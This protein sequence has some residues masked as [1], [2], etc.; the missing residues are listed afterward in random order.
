M[1]QQEIIIQTSSNLV[2][3]GADLISKL[4]YDL[5][6]CLFV[7][8]KKIWNK[9]CNN[10]GKKFF[11]Q[12]DEVLILKDPECNEK[13]AKK[14]IDRVKNYQLIIGFGSG[15]INDLCKYSA[16]QQGIKYVIFPSACSMNG[17]CSQSSSITINGHKKSIQSKSPIAI[18][19]DL[20]IL[21]TAP[22]KMIKAGI[23]DAFCLYSCW[24][25]WLLSH[26]VFNSEF[27]QQCFSM[28]I[29]IINK[30]QKNYHK[31][32]L[33][34]EE[35][36]K[37]LI[38]FLLI[39]SQAMNLANGSYPASQSEHL[40]AHCLTMKYPKQL[41]KILHG[42]L[43]AITVKESLKFQQEILQNLQKKQFKIENIKS[44]WQKKISN[45]FGKITAKEC[46][47]QYRQ[48]ILSPQKIL[49]L[50]AKLNKNQQKIFLQLQEIYK[51]N[52]QISKILKHF[53]IE[54]KWQKISISKSQ[55]FQCVS[56]AK[57]IR[58]RIT[59]LDFF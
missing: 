39:S 2:K 23:S 38:E 58:N 13:F 16:S 12:I 44:N 8:D 57:F 29:E 46:I 24:F 32:N 55:Y 33:N 36:Q 43:I 26:L 31:F 53:K 18:F 7:S 22:K 45:F 56:H 49:Q 14:I 42:Q 30:L 41:K 35:F 19:N 6:N 48:K 4:G 11:Q 25:D 15:T 5:K 40:I 1:K 37:I 21:K 34:S 27:N 47:D 20:K 17:Y 3:Q 54:D 52:S 10:F 28:Q 59:C 9:Y 50:N 51:K